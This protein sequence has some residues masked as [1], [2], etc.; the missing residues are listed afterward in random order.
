MQ[1]SLTQFSLQTQIELL[2]PAGNLE[3][4]K[5]AVHYG[6]DAVYL[7][8]SDLSLRAKADNFDSVG[9]KNA[10]NYCHQLNVKVY[11]TI[12]IFPHNRDLSL[13]KEHLELL[14][15]LQPDA[16]ILSDL[17]VFDLACNI[18]PNIPIHI[19]TQAN[20]TNLSSARFWERIG[21]KRLILSRELTIPEIKEIRQ[22]VSIE[23][24][25][26][27]HG[28]ICISYSGRCYMSSFLA[29]RSANHGSCTNSCRW[30]YTLMEEK[31][32]GEYYPVYEND[33]GTYVLS[34][35]DLCMINHLDK[36]AGAGVNSFKIEG[37][38][39]G[40]NYVAGVVKV[41]RDA[42]NS[43]ENG[44][45]MVKDNWMNEL[46]M[47][48]NRGFTTGMF[49]G[50]QPDTDYNH[51]ELD[52]YRTTHTFVGII[53]S[54]TSD[55]TE[56]ALRNTLR[57]GDHLTIVCSGTDNLQIDVDWIKN[58]EG[59]LIEIGKNEEI[60]FIKSYNGINVGDIIRRQSTA[61]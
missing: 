25:C 29:S 24:E 9:I 44:R 56:I 31:R 53:K 43:I 27:V 49:L 59:V 30:N 18:A 39:K 11:I 50:R 37:R 8:L 23:L 26:F 7:G 60:V 46:L 57:V 41:Y 5:T 47:S 51:D 61:D 58:I 54:L 15:E 12:N 14:N 28:S 34:S 6:A 21:A 52:S 40:I 45:F 33:R 13:I 10:I 22:S 19:S 20:I 55:Y 1:T 42:I 17:G 38:V 2:A 35:R 16:I 32:P 4:L 48:S 36:L 3:K